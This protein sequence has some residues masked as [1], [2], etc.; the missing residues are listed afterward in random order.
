M[1]DCADSGV[2]R[3]SGA[4]KSPAGQ[5]WQSACQWSSSSLRLR[6]YDLYVQ[7]RVLGFQGKRIGESVVVRKLC[8]QTGCDEVHDFL[9]FSFSTD[10]IWTAL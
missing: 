5:A 4:V 6:L 10:K 7:V 8:Y 9:N 1:D 3:C 2:N